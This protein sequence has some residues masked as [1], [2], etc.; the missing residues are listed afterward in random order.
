MNTRYL[1]HSLL[2]ET[3][4][5]IWWQLWWRDRIGRYD[6]DGRAVRARRR[7]T[8]FEDLSR[9][10][11]MRSKANQMPRY[12]VLATGDRRVRSGEARGLRR[13]LAL[14]EFRRRR[15]RWDARQ[16]ESI[17]CIALTVRCGWEKVLVFSPR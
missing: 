2:C 14:R 3:E 11:K 17:M 12:W 8:L 1:V 9:Y 4:L 16:P 10:R 6:D 15:L 13:V 7:E 5:F